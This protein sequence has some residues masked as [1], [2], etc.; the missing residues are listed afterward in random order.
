[1]ETDEYSKSAFF[2]VVMTKMGS[3]VFTAAAPLI[4]LAIIY[5]GGLGT[6]PV[7]DRSGQVLFYINNVVAALIFSWLWFSISALIF[8]FS[9]KA[10]A[11]LRKQRDAA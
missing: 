3:A 6:V 11:K 5:Q 7:H 8:Y 1:M 4:F 9:K 10:V 2:I